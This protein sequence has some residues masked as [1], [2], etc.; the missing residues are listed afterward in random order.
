MDSS[1]FNLDPG[2]ELPIPVWVWLPKCGST[3]GG[4]VLPLV[5]IGTSC[6]CLRRHSVHVSCH[7]S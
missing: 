7:G 4:V 6:W 1:G 3:A 5:R 2:L